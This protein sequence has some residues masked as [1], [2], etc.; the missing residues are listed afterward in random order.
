MTGTSMI[1]AIVQMEIVSSFLLA[2]KQPQIKL[3]STMLLSPHVSQQK[4][5]VSL[6]FSR[7][8]TLPP[9]VLLSGCYL[10]HGQAN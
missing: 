8:E 10:F 6:M 5:W 1:L 4:F 3:V 7:E 9:G 2:L